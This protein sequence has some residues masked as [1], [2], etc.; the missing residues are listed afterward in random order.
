MQRAQP[1]PWSVNNL[2]Q[3]IHIVQNTFDLLI[4]D[5]HHLISN[6]LTLHYR[7][8]QQSLLDSD[9]YGPTADR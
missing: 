7:Y 5:H 3:V 4:V 2:L 1:R 6:A 9:G 8:G